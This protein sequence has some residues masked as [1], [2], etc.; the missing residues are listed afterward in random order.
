MVDSI[1]LYGAYVIAGLGES[2]KC[3]PGVWPS[4]IEASNNESNRLAPNLDQRQRKK[5]RCQ[6][7]AERQPQD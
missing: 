6:S 3:R 5:T 2:S 4:G 7:V 1:P